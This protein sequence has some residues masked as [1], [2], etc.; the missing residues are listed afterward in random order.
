MARFKDISILT[1]PIMG[2]PRLLVLAGLACLMMSVITQAMALKEYESP[3]GKVLEIK[4]QEQL[5]EVLEAINLTESGPVY[6][7]MPEQLESPRQGREEALNASLAL[8]ISKAENCSGCGNWTGPNTT[9]DCCEKNQDSTKHKEG[10]TCPS[11]DSGYTAYDGCC[12]HDP[13]DCKDH[14]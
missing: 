4:T 1:P 11:V 6:L 7:L 13:P 12:M 5:A 10:S 8:S 9:C 14:C 2:V 3:K